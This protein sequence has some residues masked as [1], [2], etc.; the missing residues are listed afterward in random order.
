[1]RLP[2]LPLIDGAWTA[3]RGIIHITEIDIFYLSRLLSP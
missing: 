2:A 3:F 1:M